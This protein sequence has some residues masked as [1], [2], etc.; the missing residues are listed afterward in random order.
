MHNRQRCYH[1]RAAD[2]HAH[3]YDAFRC[4]PYT[5]LDHD[6]RDMQV[7]VAGQIVRT[8][9]EERVLRNAYIRADTYQRLV[10]DPRVLTEPAVVAHLKIT[11]RLHS[12]GLPHPATRADASAKAA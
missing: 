2:G 8:G 11:R 1:C 4:N 6:R 10:V 5:V 3:L 7:H 9:G 12:N